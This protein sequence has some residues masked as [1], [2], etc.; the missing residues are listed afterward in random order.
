MAAPEEKSTQLPDVASTHGESPKVKVP[1]TKLDKQPYVGSTTAA[2]VETRNY[3][4]SSRPPDIPGVIWQTLSLKGRKVAIESYK[5]TG[6]G[7]PKEEQQGT[8]VPQPSG[9][10]AKALHPPMALSVP[11]MPTITVMKQ[12][13][14]TKIP[15]VEERIRNI[16]VARSVNKK[17]ADTNPKALAAMDKEWA[18]LEKQCAWLFDE[19]RE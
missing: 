9:S 16:C 6:F 1:Q 3:K 10:T 19:V 5:R 14:R 2:G 11:A 4:G 18:K 12:Q 8:A 7:R 17:E 13:H 15:D